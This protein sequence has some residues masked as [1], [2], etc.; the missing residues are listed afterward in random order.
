MLCR[1]VYHCRPSEL[2][3]EKARDLIRHMACMKV[4]GQKAELEQRKAGAKAP[5][6]RSA[7]RR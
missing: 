4:E 2:R 3:Q 7:K 6:R 1:D 5:R